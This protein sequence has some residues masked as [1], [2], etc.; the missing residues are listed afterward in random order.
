MRQTTRHLFWGSM[1]D[2]HVHTLVAVHATS[3]P[4]T[5]PRSHATIL[6]ALT[7]LERYLL[8]RGT[9][10]TS[11]TCRWTV[12]VFKGK[13]QRLCSLRNTGSFV[14]ESQERIDRCG[15]I[16]GAAGGEDGDYEQGCRRDGEFHCPVN[17]NA[18]EHS[19]DKMD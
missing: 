4:Q 6:A 1:G 17:R 7:A 14:A 2:R 10:L 19:L 11:L 16:C 8:L 3:M 9:P 15:A 12:L 13:F 5:W 18:I